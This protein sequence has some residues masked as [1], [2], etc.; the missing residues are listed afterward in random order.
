MPKDPTRWIEAPEV[1]DMAERLIPKYH[2][3][4][5]S[6]AEEIRYVFRNEA[7]VSKGRTVWGKAH[8]IT[9]MPCYLATNAP[10]DAN[11][12]DDVPPPPA[13]MFVMEVAADIWEKLTARQREA[14]VDHELMHFTIEMDDN[15]GL[16]RGIRG[17]DV[18]EFREVV[19]RH[20]AW[21]PDLAEFA[22]ALQLSLL[23]A[24]VAANLRSVPPEPERDDSE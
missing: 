23:T 9:G 20:G 12:F 3:H 7:Q 13:D 17:H 15:A 19:E 2:A 8:K 18:E 4:L 24:P 10:G 22:E 16:V 5:R 6:W 21:K 1:K 14:L 11:A